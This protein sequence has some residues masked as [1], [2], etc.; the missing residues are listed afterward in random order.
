MITREEFVAALDVVEAYGKQLQAILSMAERRMGVP[1]VEFVQRVELS[2]RVR[3]AL[4]SYL[5][6][7]RGREVIYLEEVAEFHFI[8]LRNTG[9]LSWKEFSE[10]RELEFLT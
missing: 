3:S 1:L 6:L 7:E 9:R 5:E 8:R 2:P 10:K 4:Y